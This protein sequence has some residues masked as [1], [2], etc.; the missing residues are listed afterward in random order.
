MPDNWI[1]STVMAAPGVGQITIGPPVDGFCTPLADGIIDGTRL[2]YVVEDG[3][4]KEAGIGTLSGG[5]LLFDRSNIH[6]TLVAG[7]KTKVSPTPLNLT[8]NAV[9][10]IGP[11]RAMHQRPLEKVFTMVGAFDKVF[12]GPQYSIPFFT[13]LSLGG[14]GLGATFFAELN[15]QGRLEIDTIN[16]ELKVLATMGSILRLGIYEQSGDD[17]QLMHETGDVDVTA[18]TGDRLISFPGDPVVLQPGLYLLAVGSDS[19]AQIEGNQSEQQEIIPP[20]SQSDIATRG[21][22]KL[23]SFAGT[24][25]A[26]VTFDNAADDIANRPWIWFHRV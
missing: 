10:T 21:L 26:T 9:L 22:R 5:G 23:G 24:M 11:I 2:E 6:E 8:A 4:S 20:M 15:L 14:G 12:R 19:N 13:T 18:T 1:K 7:V 25:P 16:F 3:T 17:W